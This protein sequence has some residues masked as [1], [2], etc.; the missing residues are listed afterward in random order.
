MVQERGLAVKRRGDGET[1]RWGDGETGRRG[2]PVPEKAHD[3]SEQDTRLNPADKVAIT[4]LVVITILVLVF[5]YRI[6]WWWVLCAGHAI[7]V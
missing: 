4:Y 3:A 6:P 1:G 7:L 2:D 5:S